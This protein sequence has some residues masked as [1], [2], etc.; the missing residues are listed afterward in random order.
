VYSKVTPA[1][2]ELKCYSCSSYHCSHVSSL[3]RAIDDVQE[4]DNST[5]ALFK[6]SL[7]ISP[8]MRDYFEMATRSEEKV[9]LFLTGIHVVTFSNKNFIGNIFDLPNTVRVR[10]KSCL[11][12]QSYKRLLSSKTHAKY[13][14]S[15]SFRHL[16]CIEML[17]HSNRGNNPKPEI[18]WF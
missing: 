13:C 7:Q 11:T 5:L 18:N 15:C 2:P 16:T 3:A 6:F 1:Q 14:S 12:R 10:V 4:D 17:L 9:Q 8:E